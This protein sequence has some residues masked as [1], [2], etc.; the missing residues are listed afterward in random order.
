MATAEELNRIRDGYERFG[1]THELPSG[2]FHPEIVWDLTTTEAWAEEEVYR[3]HDGVR[4]FIADW[5]D[6]WED[7]EF[8]PQEVIDA[9][10]RVVVLGHQRATAKGS[11]VP[12]EMDWAHVITLRDGLI[13]RVRLYTD[14]DQALRDAG[15]QRE[16]Q[17]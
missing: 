8:E 14:R 2:M 9:G 6:P 1:R 16:R 10:G 11:G 7:Y 3:G 17:S 4:H 5:L 13:A 15:W 12:V